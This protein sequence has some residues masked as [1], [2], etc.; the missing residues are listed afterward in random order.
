MCVESADVVQA[1]DYRCD[2]LSI[3]ID[4][5]NFVQLMCTHVHDYALEEQNTANTRTSRSNTIDTTE[6]AFSWTRLPTLYSRPFTTF[7]EIDCSAA[8]IRCN[9]SLTLL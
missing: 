6:T 9:K 7:V 4:V 2:E 5:S 3:Q 8:D 1:V